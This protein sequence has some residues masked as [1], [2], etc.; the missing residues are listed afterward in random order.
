VNG[1][2]APQNVALVTAGAE[3]RIGPRTTLSAKFDGE[4]AGGYQSYAGTGT[5]RYAFN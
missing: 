3:T 4:L 2:A 5:L 1:A